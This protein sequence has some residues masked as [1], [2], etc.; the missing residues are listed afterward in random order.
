VATEPALRRAIV[1]ACKRLDQKGLVAGAEGNVSARTRGGALV[2]P[3]GR[4]KADIRASELVPVD[5]AGRGTRRGRVPSSE[6]AMHAAIYAERP[7]VGAVVHAHPVAATAFAAAKKPLPRGA[8]AE[9]AAIVGPVPMV[10][11]HRPGTAALGRAVARALRGAN[12]AFLANH[13]TVAVGPTMDVALQRMESLEQGARIVLAARILGGHGTLNAGELRALEAAWR[14]GAG[15]GTTR[16][17]R[18]RT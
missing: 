5:G 2:T 7:D 4:C 13:G 1:R 6:V 8:L 12:V 15:R 14:A 17:R 16:G 18:T 3:A 11:Y 10:P 9:L